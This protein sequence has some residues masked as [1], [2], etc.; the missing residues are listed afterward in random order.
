MRFLVG[1]RVGVGALVAATAFGAAA[2][3]S[4]APKAAKTSSPST[5][6]APTGKGGDCT[7]TK[8][9]VS[10]VTGPYT[11]VASLGPEEMMYTPQQVAAQHPTSGEVML[12]GAMGT[13]GM[14]SSTTMAAAQSAPL[15]TTPMQSSPTTGMPPG[16]I[17]TT[18]SMGGG[19]AANTTTPMTAAPG[20]QMN[21]SMT[22]VTVMPGGGASVTRHLEVHICTTADG[23][24][25]TKANPTI[26]LAVAGGDNAAEIPVDVAVMQGIGQGTSDLHYGN[27]VTVAP[28][29]QYAVA[30]TVGDAIG[31]FT[32]TG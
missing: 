24:V 15:A 11:M 10:T 2:C 19:A 1:R 14:G 31:R 18:T 12:Q 3:G 13:T 23:K 28:N 26:T 25:V 32:L 16:N 7:E 9:S 21:S 20:A 4:Q 30:V 6:A 29:T 27:N 5:T 8:G 17:S 22:T